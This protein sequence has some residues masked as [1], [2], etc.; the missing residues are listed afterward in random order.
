MPDKYLDSWFDK[1]MDPNEDSAFRNKL[2]GLEYYIPRDVLISR[3]EQLYKCLTAAD[4]TGRPLDKV[5]LQIWC[6]INELYREEPQ[7]ILTTAS[8]DMTLHLRHPIRN[9][10]MMANPHLS[11]QELKERVDEE[12]RSIVQVYEPQHREEN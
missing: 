12:I 7:L 5:R 1:L 8:A 6:R 10:I 9:K 3:R 4:T 2:A 11:F